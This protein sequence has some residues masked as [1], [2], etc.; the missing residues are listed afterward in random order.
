M[1]SSTIS[2]SSSCDAQIGKVLELA[3]KLGV[4]GTPTLFFSDGKRTPGYIPEQQLESMLNATVT[5]K[6]AK[7]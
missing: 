3:Q 6:L 7:N 2:M 5:Q 1:E 4:K